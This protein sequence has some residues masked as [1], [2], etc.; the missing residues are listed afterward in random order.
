MVTVIAVVAVGGAECAV[1]VVAESA[2]AIGGWVP[3]GNAIA[4]ISST[5]CSEAATILSASVGLVIIWF[6]EF[7]DGLGYVWNCACSLWALSCMI[8]AIILSILFAI[9]LALSSYL[10]T[11]K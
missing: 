2:A 9:F 8:T 6:M 4:M 3:E 1:C 11:S 5:S 7:M 10:A